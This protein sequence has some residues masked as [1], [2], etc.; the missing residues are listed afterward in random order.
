[1][2]KIYARSLW[3]PISWSIWLYSVK[4]IRL[5]VVLF[6]CLLASCGFR[7]QSFDGYPPVFAKTYIDAQDHYTNFYRDFSASLEQEGVVLVS[8]PFDAT[9]VVRIEKD[10][11][12]QR[13]LTVSGRNIPTE[14]DVYYSISYS[15][16]A[17]GKELLS[18]RTLSSSQDY[19]YDETRVLGKAREAKELR[20]AI[21][22]DLVRQV[23]QEFSRL[24]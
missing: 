2:V 23:N 5:S 15:V 9:A 13:V 12:G 7:L 22:K 18:S 6:S 16:W 21:S 19:T 3:F 14:Y 1:M 24:H 10:V 17:D 11:S 4:F 20:E 8:S